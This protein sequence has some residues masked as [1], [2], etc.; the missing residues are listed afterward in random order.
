MNER[1]M[2]RMWVN[3][4]FSFRECFRTKKTQRNR[5]DIW[6]RVRDLLFTSVCM[7]SLVL[8]KFHSMDQSWEPKWEH[9][10][11]FP[12]VLRRFSLSRIN[13]NLISM[14]MIFVKDF[15]LVAKSPKCVANLTF[16][17][18]VYRPWSVGKIF[19]TLVT[20]R[21]LTLEELLRTPMNRN[22][23]LRKRKTLNSHYHFLWRFRFVTHLAVG[24]VN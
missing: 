10:A 3:K 6:R 24:C 22:L 23:S 12:M 8:E 7:I 16:L 4:L 21:I 14:E 5:W 19:W 15:L 11:L 9:F 2:P 20:R 17:R 18:W 13:H 1:K